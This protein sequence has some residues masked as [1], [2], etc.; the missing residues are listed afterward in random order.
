MI[1]VPYYPLADDVMRQIIKLQLGRIADRL[2]QNHKAEF[3]Y[4]D[5]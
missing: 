3:I 1:V 5:A 4:D 2:R